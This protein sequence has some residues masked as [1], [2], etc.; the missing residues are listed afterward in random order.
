MALIVSE[1]KIIAQKNNSLSTEGRL[2][3]LLVILLLMSV[4]TIGFASLGAWVVLPFAGL[5]FLG[6]AYAL[7]LIQLHMNDYESITI[8]PEHVA[9]VK[10]VKNELTETIFKRYWAAVNLRQEKNANRLFAKSALIISSHGKEVEFGH[11]LVTDEQRNQLVKELK[12][13]IKNIN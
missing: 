8:D 2:K 7:Y 4:V 10:C 9:V 12:S 11:A 13:K 3:L 6:F 5:E 1:N